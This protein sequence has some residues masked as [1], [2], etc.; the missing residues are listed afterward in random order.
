MLVTLKPFWLIPW[1]PG[2]AI[3]PSYLGVPSRAAAAGFTMHDCGW[4]WTQTTAC[5]ILR[6][7]ASNLR[8]MRELHCAR[9]LVLSS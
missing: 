3:V 2:Q 5:G 7:M 4:L 1:R 8:P 9:S 6:M